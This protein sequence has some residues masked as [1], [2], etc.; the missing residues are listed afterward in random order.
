MAKLNLGVPWI[1]PAFEILSP[2]GHVP[3]FF[4]AKGDVP[5][6]DRRVKL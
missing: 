4:Q 5:P 6:P 2:A 3:T 1:T